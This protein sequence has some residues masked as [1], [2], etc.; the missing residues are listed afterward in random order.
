MIVRVPVTFLWQKAAKKWGKY[1]T[2]MAYNVVYGCYMFVFLSIGKGSALLGLITCAVWGVAYAGHWLLFDLTSDAVDYDELLTGER[3]E[4]QFTMARELV[5][6]ICEIPA[7]AVPF[8]LMSYFNYNPDLPEQNEAVQW[9]IRGSL[10]VVPGLAGL[11]GAVALL[12]YNLRT[13]AQQQD[14]IAGIQRHQEGKV[15]TDPLTGLLLPPINVQD[16]GSV[17]YEGSMVACEP[18]KIL[19]Y[20]FASEIRW[21]CESGDL[22]RLKVK[23]ALVMVF[24]ALLAVPGVLL[25]VEG[26]ASLKQ[27]DSSWS[28]VGIILLGFAVIGFL[29]SLERLRQA[30]RAVGKVSR[31]DL[32]AAKLISGAYCDCCCPLNLDEETWVVAD[33]I[34]A[35]HGYAVE[36]SQVRTRTGH[37]SIAWIEGVEVF[38]EKRKLNLERTSVNLNAWTSLLAH[39]CGFAAIEAG[40]ALQHMDWF[41]E[42]P[43]RALVAVLINQVSIGI[44]FRGMDLCRIATINDQGDE[45]V[46]LLNEEIKEAENDIISLASSFL[47]VQVIRFVLSGQLPDNEGHMEPYVPMG[48]T[49]LGQLLACGVASVVLSVVLSCIPVNNSIIMWL[50]EKFQNI[51]GMIFAWCTL[52]SVSMFVR[53][54]EV[55]QNV[56]DTQLYPN[57]RHLVSA[58]VLS[59]CSLMAIRVLDCIQDMGASFPRILQNMIN[60]FS[61]LIGLSWEICFE[62]GVSELSMETAHPTRMKL[63]FTICAVGIVLPAWRLYVVKRVYDLKCKAIERLEAKKKL[64]SGFNPALQHVF[65]GSDHDQAAPAQGMQWNSSALPLAAQAAQAAQMHGA[66]AAQAAQ[67]AQVHVQAAQAAHAMARQAAESMRLPEPEHMLR[68]WRRMA[69]FGERME[70]QAYGLGRSLAPEGYLNLMSSGVL[71]P[72]W[73]RSLRRLPSSGLVRAAVV[74]ARADRPPAGSG[75]DASVWPEA[76]RQRIAAILQL[77]VETKPTLSGRDWAATLWATARCRGKAPQQLL[78]RAVDAVQSGLTDAQSS[79][80]ARCFWAAASLRWRE[81]RFLAGARMAAGPL[82]PQCSQQDLSNI[83]WASATLGFNRDAWIPEVVAAYARRQDESQEPCAPQAVANLLWSLAKAYEGGFGDKAEDLALSLETAVLSCLQ[84]AQPL[85]VANILWSLAKLGVTLDPEGPLITGLSHRMGELLQEAEIQ[86]LASAAWALAK[87]SDAGATGATGA[88]GAA[89]GFLR[90]LADFMRLCVKRTDR[91]WRV[92]F[93]GILLS[94]VSIMCWSFARVMAKERVTRQLLKSA[95]RQLPSFT[96]EGAI[97]AQEHANLLSAYAEASETAWAGMEKPHA[98]LR[99]LVLLLCDSKLQL[100]GETFESLASAAK[101]LAKLRSRVPQARQWL[102]DASLCGA[103][104]PRLLTASLLVLQEKSSELTVRQLQVLLDALALLKPRKLAP[105]HIWFLQLVESRLEEFPLPLLT[106]TLWCLQTL[107]SPRRDLTEML[108]AATSRFRGAQLAWP[109]QAKGDAVE[110]SK[111]QWMRL[112]NSTEPALTECSEPW[113]IDLA[114]PFATWLDQF[115]EELRNES[116]LV[117]AVAQDSVLRQESAAARYRALSS[118]VGGL[119]PRWTTEAAALGLRFLKASDVPADLQDQVWPRHREGAAALQAQLSFRPS[120]SEEQLAVL[121]HFAV[122]GPEE[123]S[124]SSGSEESDSEEEQAP[125]LSFGSLLAANAAAE[126]HAEF[127]IL[128]RLAEDLQQKDRASLGG[129]VTLFTAKP[130]CVSCLGAMRQLRSHWPGIEIQVGYAGA[131]PHRGREDGVD[132][133]GEGVTDVSDTSAGSE[134]AALRAALEKFLRSQKSATPVA[135]L[136]TDPRVRELWKHVC[137]TG[138]R[139]SGKNV[140]RKKREWQDKLKYFLA[141]HPAVFQLDDGGTVRLVDDKDKDVEAQERAEGFAQLRSALEERAEGFAQ[142]RS[143]LEETILE[144]LRQG[145]TS[146]D[147]RGSGGYV[148][149]EDVACTPRV[150]KLWKKLRR[151]PTDR[152]AFY[153]RHEEAFEVWSPGKD[154]EAADGLRS[155]VRIRLVLKRPSGP[156]EPRGLQ[157]LCTSCD[158]VWQYSPAQ[159]AL[160]ASSPYN[161]QYSVTVRQ[162][163]ST[164]VQLPAPQ[165]VPCSPAPRRSHPP[166]IV[167]VEPL[168]PKLGER[169]VSQ[170]LD[171]WVEHPLMQRPPP[172]G[173]RSIPV[174]EKPELK[175]RASRAEMQESYVQTTPEKKVP[176][177]PVTVM[178]VTPCSTMA[179]MKAIPAASSAEVSADAE[180]LGTPLL[181]TSLSFGHEETPAPP[182]EA[183]TTPVAQEPTVSE[184]ACPEPQQEPAAVTS[185]AETPQEAAH[186]S[187]QALRAAVQKAELEALR[188]ALEQAVLAG[189]SW[190]LIEWAHDKFREMENQA[191][192]LRME[193][194]ARAALQQLMAQNASAETLS[195]AC[196]HAWQAGVQ[197]DE[198]DAAREEIGRRHYQQAA[199]EALLAAFQRGTPLELFQQALQRAEQAG[200]ATGLLKHANS[201]LEDLQSCARQQQQRADAEQALKERAQSA[202]AAAQILPAMD[203]ALEAGASR[204]ALDKALQ[205]KATL[206]IHEWQARKGELSKRRPSVRARQE[207]LPEAVAAPSE[208]EVALAWRPKEKETSGS[209]SESFS[210]R[211]EESSGRWTVPPRLPVDLSSPPPRTPRA[212]HR[213]QDEARDGPEPGNARSSSAPRAAS[214]GHRYTAPSPRPQREDLPCY[215]LDAELKAKAAAKYSPEAEQ[216]AAH[217]VQ[218]VTGHPVLGDFAGALRSGAI[219]CDLVNCIRPGSIPKVNPPGMP[220]KERE[221]ISNFLRACRNFGVQEYAL[222]STDDLYE[223]KNLT[224]VVNCIYALGGAVQR[225]VPD[226][227][228]PSFGVIDTS[229]TKREQKR[230]LGPVSQTGGLRGPLERSHLDMVSNSNVRVGGC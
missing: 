160:S 71:S 189:T 19:D 104:Q 74:L 68:T 37:R 45:R 223:E 173:R 83:A 94:H 105:E 221:N 96:A 72:Q 216:S 188:L 134:P 175:Q 5:P 152:L 212:R 1:W 85:H 228:G 215:G 92:R 168:P 24:C 98:M 208:E 170:V 167:P 60:V 109:G 230:D 124:S 38:V 171:L 11:G 69:F 164:S 121:Q 138:V 2:F 61:V 194:A 156:S 139:P 4:G 162:Y 91:S 35:D 115:L 56:L 206:E 52:W 87:L 133:D 48:M 39:F 220:F 57:E 63:I 117:V 187:A 225:Y 144:L 218:A 214:V 100:Q 183:V 140:P 103:L 88:T 78:T 8:L 128:S 7:D 226:F 33:G 211:G 132:G 111:Q 14:I 143:A 229:N 15:T 46:V 25:T 180:V 118:A 203:M 142:L 58:L 20:F 193:G 116:D 217:W 106:S 169:K 18:K 65:N 75:C 40:G 30:M 129:Q 64:E 177:E 119:G 36:E 159:K 49:A 224:S 227:T 26:W 131:Q 123:L 76:R 130:P 136:G 70:L 161:S 176:E 10:S 59:L 126:E 199:E 97:K 185:T 113:A 41:K 184:A 54:T 23:P 198:L 108:A 43:I 222:F 155:A 135:L 154:G 165:G 209:S 178:E 67:T 204:E 47:V 112:V 110:L 9:I 42:S 53:E 141:H 148:L 127:K 195:D 17:E 82:L 29:F 120:P 210:S 89:H 84:A 102:G 6:K 27:G 114:R 157:L 22:G 31:K 73:Q 147:H 137:A 101:S 150:Y 191:W 192:K 197:C 207:D 202:T 200:V 77:M 44:L 66:A 190:E 34:R 174:Q 79:D 219:L 55:F 13:E 28:P 21:A 205:K 86:H 186:E 145:R 107:S 50:L 16:D 182:N 201:R 163:S 151:D 93:E 32:E 80:L 62:S 172:E 81:T 125:P 95:S 179:T 149:V 153:L 158:Q 3:R 166:V 122:T 213:R 12:W 99:Q 51:T 146:R 90:S 196:E 181:P